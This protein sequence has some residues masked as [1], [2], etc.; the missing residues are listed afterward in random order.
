MI[1][2][3]SS[4]LSQII[5]SSFEFTSLQRYLKFYLNLF[6]ATLDS[7]HF[8]IILVFILVSLDARHCDTK[9]G[10]TQFTLPSLQRH[11]RFYLNFGNLY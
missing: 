5:L 8:D 10:F 6:L 2:M 7:C 3:S 9:L 1:T 4:I 11:P